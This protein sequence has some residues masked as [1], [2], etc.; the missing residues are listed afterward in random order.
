MRINPK[1]QNLVA[2]I[3]TSEHCNCYVPTAVGKAVAASAMDLNQGIKVWKMLHH[4][5]RKPLILATRGTIFLLTGKI[6]FHGSN[7]MRDILWIF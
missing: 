7:K 5:R 4:I 2:Y 3:L 6:D 1:I